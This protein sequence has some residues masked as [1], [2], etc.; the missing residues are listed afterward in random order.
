MKDHY[1]FFSIVI[2]FL[3]ITEAI[4][5]ALGIDISTTVWLDRYTIL[6]D[7]VTLRHDTG[8]LLKNSS[9]QVITSEIVSQFEI[10]LGGGIWAFELFSGLPIMDAMQF[11]AYKN[12]R[13]IPNWNRSAD[14][15]TIGYED[16]VAV[17]P[18]SFK[19][20]V[21]KHLTVSQMSPKTKL[22]KPLILTIAASGTNPLTYQWHKLTFDP[23]TYHIA[24]DVPIS[25]ATKNSYKISKVTASD[26][27]TYY[28]VVNNCCSMGSNFD[29]WIV[30]DPYN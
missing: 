16:F 25:G 30:V 22:G 3:L 17:T 20:V 29:D 11:D 13:L 2:A 18:K 8:H 9:F 7:G 15:Y 19:P 21:V 26:L 5:S 10:D 4:P 14:V 24:T 1:R 6:A 28:C 27:A 23:V 12:E